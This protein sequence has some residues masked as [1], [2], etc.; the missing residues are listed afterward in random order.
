MRES[1]SAEQN[2]KTTGEERIDTL[3]VMSGSHHLGD[4]P[5]FVVVVVVHT[6]II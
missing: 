5:L 1:T 4:G 3:V 2:A 6:N